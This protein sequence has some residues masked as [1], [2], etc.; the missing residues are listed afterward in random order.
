MKIL[1]VLTLGIMVLLLQKQAMAADLIPKPLKHQQKSEVFQLNQSTKIV[2]AESL[3]D[4][5]KYLSES[6]SAPTGW[7]LE[8]VEA[9]KAKKNSIL[10]QIDSS[11]SDNIE[12]YQLSVST[13][14]VVITGQSS[15]GVFN[16]MQTMFQLMPSKVYNKLRQRNVNW[17][18]QGAEIEDEPLYSWRGM[19][20]DASRYFYDKDYVLHLIDMMGMYKMNV[21]H[22]HLIDD[23]GWRLEIKKYPKLTSIGGFRGEGHERTGGYYTQEDLKEIVAYASL[24]NVEVIPEIEI[25][26]H[27]LAA[28]AAY[29]HLSCTEKEFKVPLQHFISRDLYCVG[30][31]STFEFLEDVFKET[32]ELFPSKYIHIGGDEARYDRWAKCPHCQ[33]RKKDLGLKNEA[34]LQVY[35]TKRVQQMVKKYGKT[36]VGWDEMLEKGLEDK[37]V[38]MVWHNKKKA[39]SG[40]KDGHDVVMALTG[41][42]YF[43]VA[44]SK[45]PGEVKA[46]TWLPPISLEKTYA[47]NPMIKGLDEKYRPQVLG[48]HA[49]LWSDQF[50]HGTILQEIEPLNENRSEKYFD[51][52]TFPRMA[53]LAE[54]VWTPVE[55]KNWDDFEMRM[56]SHYPRLDEA[57]YGYRVPQPKLIS[58]EKKG[59]QFEIRLEN[60][61]DGAQIRYTTDGVKPNPYSAVYEAPVLVDRLSDFQAIT[62]VNRKQYSLPLYFPEKYEQFKKYGKFLS[63]WKPA[64]I[65]GKEFGVLEMNATGKIDSNGQYELAFLFTEGSYR[66]DIQSVE[67]YKNGNK[68]TE[69]IHDGFTGGQSKNNIYKFTI[70]QYETGAGFT[71][72]AKVR[73]DL[74]NDSYGVVFIKK[75]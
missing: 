72:K 64:L 42:C 35:F 37:A 53:A 3:N 23:A 13:G 36:I 48:G 46:A 15:A 63:E 38:G 4:L 30:K 69:D 57:G 32:F 71:I 16:A 54:A 14:Q 66:L 11:I 55:N 67:V 45:I 12:A 59:K 18:I 21:L 44:E 27:T 60:V 39:I 1:R 31:E 47:L 17:T 43:D 7:D 50:I 25:P 65:K 19:M 68:I 28:I 58:K 73:G 62:V 75:K 61:V 56:A 2:Y 33:K 40:T 74:G 41:H 20:L 5:A 8:L 70:D 51:Y 26:A 9:K 24:R 6:L 29:P 34:D 22:L 10:L 49:T 52:L